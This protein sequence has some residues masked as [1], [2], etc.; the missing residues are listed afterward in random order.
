MIH[1]RGMS[2]INGT[3]H[4]KDNQH[5]ARNAPADYP[6]WEYKLDT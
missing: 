5:K 3:K 2:L 4:H 1:T 6:S